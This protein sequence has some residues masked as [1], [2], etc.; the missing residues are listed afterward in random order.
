[1]H[2]WFTACVIVHALYCRG[3]KTTTVNSNLSSIGGKKM[4][5]EVHRKSKYLLND[6]MN[7]KCWINSNRL[8][9]K[10]FLK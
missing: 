3:G 9:H 4:D 2:Y 6:P 10:T 8:M 1:M 5:R 7:C